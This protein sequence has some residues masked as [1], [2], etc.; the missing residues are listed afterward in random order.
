M[1]SHVS[2]WLVSHRGRRRGTDRK[3]SKAPCQS[4]PPV[5]QDGTRGARLQARPAPGAVAATL[6]TGRPASC[7]SFRANTAQVQGNGG[8]VAEAVTL[9]DLQ[10]NVSPRQPRF[11]EHWSRGSK[12]GARAHPFPQSA[13]NSPTEDL[14]RAS[15][16]HTP[17]KTRSTRRHPLLGPPAW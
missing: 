6:N 16:Q 3:A 11:S 8:Q 5:P 7:G 2:S 17:T 1:P 14:L 9:R 13:S 15:T 4:E 12:A 10:Q